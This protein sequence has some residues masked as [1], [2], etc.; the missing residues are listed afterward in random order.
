VVVADTPW[1][2]RTAADGT[3]RI[4][5]A[6]AGAYRLAAWHPGLPANSAPVVQNLQIGS[7]EQRETVQLAVDAAP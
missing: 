7:G 3:A 2:A 4:D 6:P 5:G 1:F